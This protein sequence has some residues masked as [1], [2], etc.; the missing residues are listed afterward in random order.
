VEKYTAMMCERFSLGAQ[1]KVV[2]IAS[3]DGYLLQYFVQ[4][5]VPVLGVEPAANVAAKAREKGVRS[6]VEFFGTD[7]AQRLADAE[8][9]ADLVLG[10]NVLAHVPD[11][12]DFVQGVK[13]LLKPNG[14]FTF[15]FPHLLQLMEH[16]QFDTIYHEHFSYFSFG[17]VE[18]VF[19]SQGLTLFDVEEWS[20]HGGSLRI[21][22]RHAESTAHA[23]T[24][25]VATLKQRET[26]AG[27][28]SLKAYLA[29]NEQVKE[30]KRRILEV[31]IREKR[32]GKSIVLYGAAGKSNTLI[33]YC[34]I[35]TDFIDYAVDRNPYKQGHL[36]PGTRIPVYDPA[37]LRETKPDYLFVGV[38]NLK[39]EIMA[40]TS[41]IREWGGQ[42][43]IPIPSMTIA[44]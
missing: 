6:V 17:V 5:G 44:K 38:W 27:L 30:T 28:D 42:W 22:G 1:S 8:G 4:R 36:L 15:E 10:N 37:R 18:K 29:F 33:N 11:L 21:F 23:M 35:R 13:R 43:L 32:A 19:A 24:P 41:Y 3:N 26:K 7:T 31:L 12:L 25:Q 34:G 14:I 39:D 16:N 20:T 9:K 2:E 40:Q